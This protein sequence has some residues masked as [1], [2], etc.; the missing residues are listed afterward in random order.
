MVLMKY[1]SRWEGCHLTSPAI[2]NSCIKINVF[3]VII[4]LKLEIS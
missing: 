2:E 3:I 4:E 1:L